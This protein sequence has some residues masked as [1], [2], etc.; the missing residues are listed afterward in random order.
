MHMLSQL[1]SLLSA[2]LASI[3]LPV[4]PP[5]PDPAQLVPAYCERVVDG[6]TAWFTVMDDGV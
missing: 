3:I 1:I 5:M 2:V 6:D 4:S